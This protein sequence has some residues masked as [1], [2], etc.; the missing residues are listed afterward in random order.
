MFQ[1]M[2]AYYVF[3]LVLLAWIR[4]LMRSRK[5]QNPLIENP[6]REYIVSLVMY[7]LFVIGLLLKLNPATATVFKN[8]T[9]DYFLNFFI[10]V[11]L[12]VCILKRNKES[13]KNLGLTIYPVSANLSCALFGILTFTAASFLSK[14]LPSL[15]TIFRE[16]LYFLLVIALPEEIFFRGYLQTRLGYILGAWKGIIA[17]SL[18]FSFMHIPNIIFNLK[19]SIFSSDFYFFIISP[20]LGGMIFGYIFLRTR[21]VI[22]LVLLHSLVDLCLILNVNT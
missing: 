3:S 4:F 12:P 19:A 10:A 15:N 6:R 20:F 13:M 18:L 21:S 2:L 11:L 9:F 5:V 1:L 17:A 14:S 8:K 22:G 7:G 16:Y